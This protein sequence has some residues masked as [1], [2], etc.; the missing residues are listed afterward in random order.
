[1]IN[2]EN[3]INK[4][5]IGADPEMFLYSQDLEKFI[6]ICGLIGG[7]KEEPL[8]ISDKGHAV[9]EDNVAI[10]FCIPPCA[11]L[12]E[13]LDNINFTKNYIDETLLKPKGLISKCIASARFDIDDLLDPAAQ[14]FGCTP[15]F[16][17]WNGQAMIVDRTDPLLRTTGGHIHVGYE[18]PNVDLSMAIIQA[19]DLFLGVQSVLLDDDTERRK[20][21]GKAG[22]YR[23]KSYGVEY[24]SLSSFWL[25]NDNLIKWAYINTQAA[26]DFVNDGG[27]ITNPEEIQECINT[28]NRELALEI[29]NDYHIEVLRIETN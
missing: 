22:D 14:H 3:L 18:N 15:S 21:Y 11:S 13:W 8:A 17:A 24:R 4:V 23:L 7:T 16:N 9:Q 5:L 1:M 25:E 10:E 6:P 19:M 26:I 27:I 2:K 29:I 28:C 20:M 12:E